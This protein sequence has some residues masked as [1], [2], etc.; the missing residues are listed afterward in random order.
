M[1]VLI[2]FLVVALLI[3]TCVDIFLYH[4]LRELQMRIERDADWIDRE[5]CIVEDLDYE[6]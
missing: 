2:F 1:Y 4:E 5:A 3:V 6:P